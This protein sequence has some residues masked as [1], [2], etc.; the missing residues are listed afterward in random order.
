MGAPCP[1]LAPNKTLAAQPTRM[2]PTSRK[3]RWSIRPY[4]DYYKPEAYT[5]HRNLYR[6]DSSVN[7]Q[8][9]ACATP[10]HGRSGSAMTS[11]RASV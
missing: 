10:R 8:T 9:T 3:K 6:K 1:I 5:A 4:Y 2:K 7:E 11:H